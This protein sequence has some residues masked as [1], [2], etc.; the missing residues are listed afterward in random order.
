MVVDNYNPSESYNQSESNE[1]GDI[2]LDI[3][4]GKKMFGNKNKKPRIKMQDE[5]NSGMSVIDKGGDGKKKG[6][7]C[8]IF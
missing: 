6:K 1:E 2:A 7:Q 3:F 4:G 5:K 8:T